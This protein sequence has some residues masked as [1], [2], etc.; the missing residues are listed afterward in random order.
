M[1]SVSSENLAKAN[2]DGP[3]G[4]E[5]LRLP[6][7]AEWEYACRALGRDTDRFYPQKLDFDLH[8]RSRFSVGHQTHE[9][10]AEHDRFIVNCQYDVTRN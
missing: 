10:F 3:A 5:L 9:V 7:E 2:A 1:D 8:L 4:T 6:T